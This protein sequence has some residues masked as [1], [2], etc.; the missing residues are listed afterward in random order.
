MTHLRQIDSS[1]KRHVQPMSNRLDAILF[2]ETKQLFVT[3]YCLLL[4]LWPIFAVLC[5]F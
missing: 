1:L 3:W 2:L 4:A 5:L